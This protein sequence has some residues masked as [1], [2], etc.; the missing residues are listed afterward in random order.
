MDIFLRL[1]IRFYAR[2]SRCRGQTMVEYAMILA[3]IAAIAYAGFH[4]MGLAILNGALDEVRE[5]LS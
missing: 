3:A 5:L 1:Q 2:L 4:K